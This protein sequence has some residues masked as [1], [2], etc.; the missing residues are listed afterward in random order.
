MRVTCMV[1]GWD[2]FEAGLIGRCVPATT[3][4]ETAIEV[5]CPQCGNRFGLRRVWDDKATGLDRDGSCLYLEREPRTG[6]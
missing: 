5:S 1:C 3:D 4:T 6:G 2:G